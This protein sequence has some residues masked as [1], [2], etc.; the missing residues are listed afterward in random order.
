MTEFLHSASSLT[1]TNKISFS[2]RDTRPRHAMHRVKKTPLSTIASRLSRR[3]DRFLARLCSANTS[4]GFAALNPGYKEIRKQNAARRMSSDVPHLRMRLALI[5]ARARGQLSPPSAC[6]QR[7]HSA[8]M[9]EGGQHRSL[10]NLAAPP[11]AAARR[12]SC[13]GEQDGSRGLGHHEQTGYLPTR[14]S[15][16][17]TC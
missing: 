1:M 11:K 16:S 4:P 6:Q 15:S 14:S 2:R 5:A 7:T 17:M 9:L 8:A 13:F 12:G 3:W 10:V